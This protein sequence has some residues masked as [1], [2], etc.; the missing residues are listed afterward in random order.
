VS[1]D[2]YYLTAKQAAA[3]LG[4]TRATLYAYT[5]RGQLR[6]EAVPGR[7]KERR[8][9][10]EDIERLRERKETRRDPARAAA[11]GLHWGSPVLESGVTLIHNGRF[12]YRGHDAVA[13]AK[14]ASLEQVAGL[15]WA[16]DESEREKLF[17]RPSALSRR[18]LAP[19]RAR[20][21]DSLTMLQ[22]A[23][24]LA[25]AVDLASYDLTA[26]AVRL[27][28]A[29]IIRLLTSIVAKHDSPTAVHLALQARWAPKNDAVADVIRTA[30]V[31]CADHELNV[32]AFAA[33]CAASAGATPYD[34]VSAALATFK[35]YKH[36][37]A[38][39]QVLALLAE[40]NTP[41]AARGLVANRLRRGERLPG[42]GHRL[43]PTGDPRALQLLRLA[44]SSGN[45]AEWQR[46]RGLMKTGSELLHDLPN[47]DFGLAAVTRV[48]G[49]PDQAPA[50]LFALGRTIGWIAHAI[51]EYA[52]GQLIRPRARYTGP[53]PQGVP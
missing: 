2:R 22:A 25:G 39:E 49:L 18:Q 47:L 11:R 38:A 50:L 9:H 48:Y 41:R 43:Y 23:L 13:L 53:A 14:T 10:R 51:E 34:V 52:S 36:G 7:P 33:R 46:V 44:E 45:G 26:P 6:S 40:M 1:T 8:Y 35:G 3:V 21:H 12:Y 29:R 28:G 15:L 32:S 19:L 37:G 42:F 27:T 16:A 31:L 17:T 20:A 24:P 30:L 5:S 4:V